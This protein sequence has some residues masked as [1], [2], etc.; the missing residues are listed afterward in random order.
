[1]QITIREYPCPLLEKLPSP[2]NDLDQ[3]YRAYLLPYLVASGLFLE[4]EGQV[5]V[6]ALRPHDQR[7]LLFLVR[8]VCLDFGLEQERS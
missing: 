4:T 8:R 2:P 7:L 6:V 1:M 5:E 3:T